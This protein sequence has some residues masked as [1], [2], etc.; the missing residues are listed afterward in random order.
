M[1]RLPFLYIVVKFKCKQ[2]SDCCSNSLQIK[3][4]LIN[5][6]SPSNCVFYWFPF[7]GFLFI[8]IFIFFIY[9]FTAGTCEQHALQQQMGRLQV[10]MKAKVIIFFPLRTF[11]SE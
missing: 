10:R 7:F 9:F 5:V 3:L 1:G 4:K 2:H 8:H 6:S 11:I